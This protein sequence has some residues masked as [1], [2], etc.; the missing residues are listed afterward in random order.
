MASLLFFHIHPMNIPKVPGSV[1]YAAAPDPRLSIQ[2]ERPLAQFDLDRMNYFLEG[3][4]D[5]ALETRKFIDQ[6]ERDPILAA[7]PKDYDATKAEHRAFTLQKIDRL[8]RYIEFETF[9]ELE[10]RLSIVCV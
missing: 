1:T 9:D 3:S 4:K 7:S 6:M 8:A 10:R 5:R 2:R